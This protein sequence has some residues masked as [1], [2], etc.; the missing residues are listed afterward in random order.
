MEE[1][2]EDVPGEHKG[3]KRMMKRA[4]TGKVN[5]SD[6]GKEVPR[7]EWEEGRAEEGGT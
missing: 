1:E 7:R 6:E 2:L 5:S 3:D 4:V